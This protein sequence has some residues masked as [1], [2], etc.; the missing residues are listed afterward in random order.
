MAYYYV[1]I[2]I[3]VTTVG[4]WGSIMLGTSEKLHRK[5]IRYPTCKLRKLGS[6]CTNSL[7]SLVENWSWEGRGRYTGGTSSLP[8][9]WVKILRER[10][11]KKAH[12]Q[13]ITGA[14]NKNLSQVQEQ[15]VSKGPWE[16]LIHSQDGIRCS[17]V[18]YFFV[19]C[20]HLSFCL[21]HICF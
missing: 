21:L 14:Y 13:G 7:L 11:S 4:S 3:H 16:H 19:L 6:E 1:L 17:F 9:A 2:I 10:C 5:C 15:W 18:L 12:K 20:S 8:W